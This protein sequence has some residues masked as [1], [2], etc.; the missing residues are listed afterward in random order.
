MKALLLLVTICSAQVAI[1]TNPDPEWPK[2]ATTEI[3]YIPQGTTINN[4]EGYY[5]DGTYT[6]I[7]DLQGDK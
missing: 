3:D 6:V 1:N 4:T 5:L 7:T 2:F